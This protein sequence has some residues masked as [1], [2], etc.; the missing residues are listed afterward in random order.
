MVREVKLVERRNLTVALEVMLAELS[1]LWA[2]ASSGSACA[3]SFDW[4]CQ[5]RTTLMRRQ[6]VMADCLNFAESHFAIPDSGIA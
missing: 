1:C 3:Q 5:G 4:H 6:N 2:V